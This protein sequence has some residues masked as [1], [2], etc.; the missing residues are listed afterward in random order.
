M[1][2]LALALSVVVGADGDPLRGDLRVTRWAQ[3]LPAFHTVARA[4]R[5][6]MGTEG[7]LLGGAVVALGLWLAK[8]RHEAAA[9]VVALIALRIMQPV[10]KSMVGRERPA[11]DLVE[12]RAGF[13]SE[14]FPSG[15]MMSAFVLCGM[16]AVVAW[17]LP[18]PRGV[19]V[20]V[21]AVLA[22]VVALNGTS[23]VYMGVHW[24]SDVLGGVLWGLVI[25]IPAGLALIPRPPLSTS[26][27]RGSSG[28]DAH[29]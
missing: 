28:E 8:W 16:L 7:V 26:R 12:R 20:G 18:L 19:K 1:F 29:G 15:H 3:D 4:F 23:S 10:I 22:V 2:G 11:E 14:S 25:V 27:E 9:L 13:S 24:P 5:W 17:R 21:T 6:G